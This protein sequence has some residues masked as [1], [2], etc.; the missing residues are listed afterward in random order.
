MA[1]FRNNVTPL[2]PIDLDRMES[3]IRAEKLPPVNYDPPQLTKTAA[4]DIGRITADA[5]AASHE[6]AAVALAELGKELAA[7]IAQIDTLKLAADEALKDC[8]DVAQ[9][10]REAGIKSSAKIERT[11]QLVA[12]V[13]DLCK[14]LKTKIGDSHDL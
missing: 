10:Y 14:T 3:E 4:E 11:S 5:I 6:A 7:H 12:E 13:R 9:S 1:V 2:P 8:L